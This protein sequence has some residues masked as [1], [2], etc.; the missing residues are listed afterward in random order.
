M[1]KNSPSSEK[2]A[3]FKKKHIVNMK[4][5]AIFFVYSQCYLM[6]NNAS[7]WF[8]ITCKYCEAYR[9]DEISTRQWRKF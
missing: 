9:N 3:I 6:Q 5:H 8:C 2:H 4:K 7:S 1:N